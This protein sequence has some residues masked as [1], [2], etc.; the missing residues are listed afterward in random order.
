[1]TQPNKPAPLIIARTFAAPRALVFRAWSSAE[2]MKAWFAP[3]TYTVPEAEIDFRPGG[4]FNLCMRS[5][6]GQDFW[7]K[8]HYAEIVEPER[9][10]LDLACVVDDKPRFN[11]HTTVTFETEGTGT[12][13]TVCQAYT[14]FDDAFLGAISGAPEGW[15]TTLDKLGQEVARIVAANP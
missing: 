7:S 6:E 2:H 5:P 1:M 9:L 13:L 12:L 11:A 3:A 8:G 14:I 10:V 4:A 15:R